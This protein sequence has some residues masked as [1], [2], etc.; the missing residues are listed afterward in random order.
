MTQDI[1]SID[2][3]RGEAFLIISDEIDDL[4]RK[5]REKQEAKSRRR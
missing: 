3:F 4:E 5:E 2:A 1:G